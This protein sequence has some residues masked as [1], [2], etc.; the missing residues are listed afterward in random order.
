MPWLEPYE[1]RPLDSVWVATKRR[2]VELT[3]RSAAL[4]P[5]LFAD[6]DVVPDP[7]LTADILLEMRLYSVE[8]VELFQD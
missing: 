6:V 4:P 2:G 3:L 7:P 8:L 5:T 1:Q